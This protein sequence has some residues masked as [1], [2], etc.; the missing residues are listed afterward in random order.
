MNIIQAVRD[1]NLFGRWFTNQSWAQWFIALKVIFSLPLTEDERQTFRQ[2]TQRENQPAIV[3]EF[4]AVV[5]RRGGKSLIAA[6]IAVYLACFR[7]YDSILAPGERG[8]LMVIAADKKQ[9]RVIMRYIKGFI[10]NIPMLAGMVERI[11][12]ESIDLNNR[13]SIEVHACNFRTLR[14]YTI[15]GCVAD[16]IAYWRSEDSANPDFEALNALRPAMLTVPD[17]K[18]ICISSPYARKGALWETYK[19]HFGTNSGSRLDV[20]VWQA[21]TMEMNATVPATEIADAYAADPASASSEFGGEFRS[22]LEGFISVETVEACKVNGR[23]ELPPAPS[24]RY[25]AF[26]DPSGGGSDSFTLA[27]SHNEQG[28]SILDCLREVKPPFAPSTVVQEFAQVLKQYGLSEVTG[29]KYAGQWPAD[30]FTKHGIKY[31]PAQRTKSE[32]YLECLPL[33]NSGKVQLLDQQKMIIQ[34]CSLERRTRTGGK[35]VIDHPSG[36][37]DD[38]INSAAGS[39]LL[40]QQRRSGFRGI[41]LDGSSDFSGTTNDYLKRERAIAEKKFAESL[42]EKQVEKAVKKYMDNLEKQLLG[43]S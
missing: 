2:F 11:T 28:I 40:A 3:R 31:I 19:K 41:F 21:S 39:L 18:L 27:I 34:L 10:D 35:D 29:D 16:E 37:K 14:G 42:T 4:W 32:I 7:E 24:C 25:V 9:A 30:Q 12:R 23:F 13:V 33:L 1:R 5:G 8:V 36:G 20:L 38:C 6:L 43:G 22:D 17:A 15:V 26:T